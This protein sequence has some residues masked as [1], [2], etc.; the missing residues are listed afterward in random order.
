[1]SGVISTTVVTYNRL[2][3]TKK[4]LE[5]LMKNTK[6]SH[7]IIVVDNNSTDGTKEYLATL[8]LK[9]VLLDKNYYPGYAT[10]IGWSLANKNAKL[11]HRSDNDVLYLENWDDHVREVFE[12]HSLG[13]FGVLDRKQRLRKADFG[14]KERLVVKE[15]IAINTFYPTVGGNCVIPRKIYDEGIRWDEKPWTEQNCEDVRFSNE[16]KKRGHLV[17]GA[18]KRIALHMSEG[19]YNDEYYTKT[20]KERKSEYILKVFREI[21]R[22]FKDYQR[23]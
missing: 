14:A 4:C 1:M 21:Q 9:V 5:S 7:E 12:K 10:N 11:L 16:M 23:Q 18:Q 15:N 19:N 17:A 8:P 2:D 13:Q 20:F 6:G 22:E 3:Y